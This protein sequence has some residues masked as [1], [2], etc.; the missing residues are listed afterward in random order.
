M[1][2]SQELLV[3]LNADV[4]AFGDAKFAEGVASVQPEDG[5]VTLAQEQ[6]DI[7]AAVA[8]EHTSMQALIDALQLSVDAKADLLSKVKASLDAVEA[9]YA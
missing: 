9:L 1:P 7:A 4:A 6:I 2:S 5:T 8:A 3:T